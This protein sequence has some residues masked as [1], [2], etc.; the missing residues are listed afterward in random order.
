MIR[1]QGEIKLETGRTQSASDIKYTW[2]TNA[3]KAL[4]KKSLLV[5]K[6]VFTLYRGD[7]CPSLLGSFLWP[8][9]RLHVAP[10]FI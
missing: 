1:F 7:F 8:R 9:I 3:I 4:N 2:L 10:E 6:E 5:N